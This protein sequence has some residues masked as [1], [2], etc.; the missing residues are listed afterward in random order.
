M[1]RLDILVE[2]E[3]LKVKLYGRTIKVPKGT[4][5]RCMKGSPGRCAVC[6]KEYK[7]SDCIRRCCW[8][9]LVVIKGEKTLVVRGYRVCYHCS[10]WT[11][12]SQLEMYAI[13]IDLWPESWR[14]Y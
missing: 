13:D 3:E 12:D 4:T 10:P 5:G 6:D 2:I 14:P 8:D 11:W 7:A 9:D 1:S